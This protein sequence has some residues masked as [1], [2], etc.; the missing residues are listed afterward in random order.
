MD[1]TSCGAGHGRGRLLHGGIPAAL[2]SLPR[3]GMDGC[4]LQYDGLGRGILSVRAWRRPHTDG[5]VKMRRLLWRLALAAPGRF[6]ARGLFRGLLW[7]FRHLAKRN[8]P[9]HMG[10]SIRSFRRE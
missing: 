4:D 2:H 6:A 8:A 1:F 9:K 7:H 10:P 3:F 5:A